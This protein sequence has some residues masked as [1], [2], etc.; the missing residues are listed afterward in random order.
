MLRSATALSRSAR[1]SA[2]GDADEDTRGA[3]DGTLEGDVVAEVCLTLFRGW[4]VGPNGAHV[5][6]QRCRNL[7]GDHGATRLELA[8]PVLTLARGRGFPVPLKKVAQMAGIH[9]REFS[10]PISK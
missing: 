8:H 10:R 4:P 9:S 6:R 2:R 5:V 1:R 3:I 7:E